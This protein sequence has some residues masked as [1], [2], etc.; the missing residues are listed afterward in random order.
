MNVQPH[1]RPAPAGLPHLTVHLTAHLTLLLAAL[2]TAA[3]SAAFPAPAAAHEGPC[4]C[5]SE[6]AMEEAAEEE[7]PAPLWDTEIGLAYVATA[8]NTETTNFGSS[9]E[10]NRRPDPWGIEIFATYDRSEDGDELQSERTFGGVRGK[11]SLGEHWEY[12]AGVTA[13]RDEFAGIDP[14]YVVSSGGTYRALLGPAHFLDFDLG[15]TWTDV[16]RLPPGEDES[17]AGALVGGEYRWEINDHAAFDQRLTWFPNFDEGSDWRLESFTSLESSLNEWLALRL[18]YDLR[19][20]NEP[21][22]DRDDTDTTA[23]V[24]VVVNF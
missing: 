22:G 6:E 8:G 17:F 23:R 21:V 18:G 20:Q 1:R 5:P 24:S 9:F 7:P 11:R 2:L 4:P 14:R 19:F 12:F 15:L 10:A 13:E 16:D 3:L